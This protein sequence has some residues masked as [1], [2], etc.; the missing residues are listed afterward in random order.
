MLCHASDFNKN[1]HLTE[2]NCLFVCLFVCLFFCRSCLTVKLVFS[3][4]L[5]VEIIYNWTLSIT[6]Y[7]STVY[8]DYIDPGYFAFFQASKN[9]NRFFKIVV[10]FKGIY[11]H[12]AHLFYQIFLSD[13]S[14]FWSG[15]GAGVKK[16]CKFPQ[17]PWK[18]SV[19]DRLSAKEQPTDG[20]ND[21][22]NKWHMGTQ[23]VMKHTI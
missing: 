12:I 8:L 16:A 10:S 13:S 15:A 3:S 21:Q 18:Q 4:D 9:G 6:K 1:L 7:R 11:M 23:G 20:W 19:S 14:F 2:R 5:P 22:P 17:M